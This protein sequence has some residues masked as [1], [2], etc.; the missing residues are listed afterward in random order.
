MHAS[1]MGLLELHN[2]M[3]NRLFAVCLAPFTESDD[4][5]ISVCL[6]IHSHM[7]F[8]SVRSIIMNQP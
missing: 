4:S 2:A 1:S 8:D 7:H 5:L 6:S 3:L